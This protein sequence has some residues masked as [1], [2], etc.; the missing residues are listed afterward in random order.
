MKKNLVVVLFIIS[1]LTLPL[2]SYAETILDGKA[3]ALNKLNI[4]QGDG[5]N[6]NLN[7][8]LKRSEAITFI[9]R[10]MGKED[11]V[12]ASISEYSKPTFSDVK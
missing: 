8:Q 5:V 2:M 11:L 7:G 9:V 3:A 1:L 6:F 10:I 4:L 12:K